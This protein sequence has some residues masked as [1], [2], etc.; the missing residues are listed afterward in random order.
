MDTAVKDGACRSSS[1][2]NP[3]LSPHMLSMVSSAELHL[4]QSLEHITSS[5]P[6]TTPSTGGSLL[7]ILA[8]A[9]AS[10]GLDLGPSFLLE[11]TDCQAVLP[12]SLSPKPQPPWPTSPMWSSPF[13]NAYCT[14]HLLLPFGKQT[15]TVFAWKFLVFVFYLST[16]LLPL[17]GDFSFWVSPRVSVLTHTA[18]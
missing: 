14:S 1:S 18:L 12:S 3:G 10:L 6:S 11:V 8:L 15:L 7:L 2:S 4:A 13:W 9:P 5:P 17:E 16:V